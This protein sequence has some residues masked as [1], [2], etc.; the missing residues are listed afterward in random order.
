MR[1][2]TAARKLRQHPHLGYLIALGLSAVPFALRGILG[3]QV[4]TVALIAFLPAIALITFLRGLR[5]GVLTAVLT[6]A[7]GWYA[8]VPHLNS[9][10]LKS[11]A[12]RLA[13]TPVKRT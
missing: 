9:F 12:P 6:G 7:V 10:V 4:A 11:S 3:E 5:A 2:I 8:F 13:E 1:T